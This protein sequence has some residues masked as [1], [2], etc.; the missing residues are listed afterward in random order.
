MA[1]AF[2]DA[3][4]TQS[5]GACLTKPRRLPAPG[6]THDETARGRRSRG[7]GG[8]GRRRGPV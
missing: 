2:A 3:S 5:P 1:F 6:C 8:A 4:A 7:T